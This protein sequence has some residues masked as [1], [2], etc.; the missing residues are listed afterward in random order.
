M[1][2]DAA[3]VFG[4]RLYDCLLAGM[5][6][7]K[8]VGQ[9][10]KETYEQFP[11]SNTW[12]AYQCY[13]DPYW[14]LV[15]RAGDVAGDQETRTFAT[16]WQAAVELQNLAAQLKTGALNPK[17][18]QK[19]KKWSPAWNRLSPLA[20]P[21]VLAPLG[22]A[23][24]EAEFFEESAQVLL[25]SSLVMERAYVSTN[26]I[27]T[28]ANLEARAAL[29]IARAAKPSKKEAERRACSPR[30]I[31]RFV[32]LKPWAMQPARRKTPVK[33]RWLR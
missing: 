19:L 3:A 2:D 24:G 30:S 29:R 1:D 18:G 22:R 8:A 7:G 27:E 14:K 23:Y 9:A 13:G 33:Q 10:R 17:A 28:L 4:H 5:T 20:D 16:P 31:R 26:D 21:L 6:F 25:R 32:G 11:H 15:R 12:G